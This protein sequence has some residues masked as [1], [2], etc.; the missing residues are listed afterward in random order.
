MSNLDFQL[1]V[2]GSLPAGDS[3]YRKLDYSLDSLESSFKYP[4]SY[5]WNDMYILDLDYINNDFIKFK[6][7]HYYAGGTSGNHY[8]SAVFKYD[9]FYEGSYEKTEL[10]NRIIVRI[11]KD[12]LNNFDFNGYHEQEAF[13]FYIDYVG[14]SDKL[15]YHDDSFLEIEFEK[16]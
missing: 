10:G 15:I 2:E 9:L 7:N 5:T 1:E 8:S 6:L 16:W 14:T 13:R 3:G 4:N 11:D 12:N